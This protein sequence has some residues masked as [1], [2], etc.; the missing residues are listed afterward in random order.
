ME[1]PEVLNKNGIWVELPPVPRPFVINIAD[2]MQLLT[3]GHFAS[4]VHRVVNKTGM[5]RYFLPFFFAF[6]QQLDSEVGPSFREEVEEYKKIKV[7]DFI[8]DRLKL[9][10]Y[11]HSGG[12]VQLCRGDFPW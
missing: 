12:K 1:A 11:K 8:K 6:N 2:F 4:T 7:G 9:S 5:G 3:N 10:T